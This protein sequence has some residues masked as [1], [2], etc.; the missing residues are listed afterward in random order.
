MDKKTLYGQDVRDGLKSGVDQLVDPVKITLGA[1]GKL[2]GIYD[3]RTGSQVTK[4]GYSI[5][6]TIDVSGDKIAAL[7]IDLVNQAIK[8][9]NDLVGDA[10]TTTAILCQSL[11][12]KGLNNIANDV[13]PLKLKEGV[14]L[15][16]EFAVKRISDM[17]IPVK[18]KIKQIATI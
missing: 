17:S 6:K 11:I 4:D 14:E 1:K 7:S 2:V 13:D 5:A 15:G 8:K 3:S 16:L 12:K 9:T 10:T 18:D